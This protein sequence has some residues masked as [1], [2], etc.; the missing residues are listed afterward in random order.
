VDGSEEKENGKLDWLLD[1]AE[2]DSPLGSDGEKKQDPKILLLKTLKNHLSQ[3][4]LRMQYKINVARKAFSM[5][6]I[7]QDYIKSQ[8]D[9]MY[10][11]A[12]AKRNQRQKAMAKV[13][14]ILSK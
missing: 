10:E 8:I 2:I 9:S 14:Q 7:R 13:R 11:S 1:D 5:L 6:K 3:H 12:V 4:N